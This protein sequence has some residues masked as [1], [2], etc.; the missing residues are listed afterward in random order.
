LVSAQ[1]LSWRPPSTGWHQLVDSTR[2]GI[3]AEGARGRDLL[4][5]LLQGDFLFT[6]GLWVAVFSVGASLIAQ[7][8]IPLRVRYTAGLAAL[9]YLYLYAEL[10]RTRRAIP[11]R[12]VLFSVA[13][14]AIVV[15]LGGLSVPYTDA[16]HL[17]VFFA[18]ARLA[19]RF[20]DPRM[21]GAGLLLLVP[22]DVPTHAPLLHVVFD[23]FGVAMVM[24]V[25]Q[26]LRAGA[27]RLGQQAERQ[28]AL[29]VLVSSLARARDEETL[30]AQLPGLAHPLVPSCA[31]AFWLKDPASDEFR[32]VRWAGL[33]A[34]ER[35]GRTFTPALGLDRT[36]PALI[37][38]SL[39]GTSFGQLTVL[40]PAALDGDVLGL[41]TVSGTAGRFDTGTRG[42]I[43]LVGEETGVALAR[44]QALDE[45]RN[46]TEVMEQANRLAGLAAG[47][48]ADHATALNAVLAALPEVAQADSL[49]LEWVD[50]DMIELVVGSR[51]PLQGFI[52]EK[53]PLA[54]TRTA[55]ALT[56][57]RS[58]R[59]PATGRRP[60]D[61]FCI[62]AGLR[63]LA[64]VPIR[65]AGIDGTLQLG[66]RGARPF[67]PREVLLLQLLG[68]RMAL[69][70][71]AGVTGG[72]R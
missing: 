66:R 52:P 70:F 24:L 28:A 47:H 49:H 37:T 17:L 42:L 33:P 30:L 36:Q 55:A 14:A 19:L 65:C 2:R 45:Q 40:Q 38:G 11:G 67:S 20:S 43:R 21:V 53:L 50:G 35:P 58:V 64:V 68:E 22:F 60:E 62:P 6:F 41:I 1:R 8:A 15:T 26:S 9:A 39:P 18:A 3:I 34:G 71:A 16:A 4:P 29:A 31:W 5:A 25:I 12:R 7:P 13:D 72:V 46:R 69:L 23:V 51:D 32:S 59:E 61:I 10:A 54:G 27:T 48:A 44:L 56:Y 57:G 63:Q